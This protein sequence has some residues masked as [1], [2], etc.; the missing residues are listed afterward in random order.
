MSKNRIARKEALPMEELVRLF[1]KANRLDK[2]L[3]SS[4]VFAAWNDVSGAEAYTTKRFFRDGK[5]YITLDSSV[6]RSQLTLQK[7]ELLRKI[8]ARVAGNPLLEEETDAV[9]E[10]IL[11]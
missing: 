5:L 11:K 3:R 4:Q 6:V 10:L 1:I 8:N 2:G 7:K 9:K